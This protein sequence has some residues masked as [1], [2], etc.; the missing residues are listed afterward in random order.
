MW[1]PCRSSRFPSEAR[2]SGPPVRPPMARSMARAV[3]GASGTVTTLP[4]FRVAGGPFLSLCC[5]ACPLVQRAG[6]PGCSGS[7]GGGTWIQRLAD[8]SARLQAPVSVAGVVVGDPGRLQLGHAPGGV[9]HLRYRQAEPVPQAPEPFAA[10]PGDRLLQLPPVGEIRRAGGGA[11][12]GWH[13]RCGQAAWALLIWCG[14]VPVHCG[15]LSGFARLPAC[16]RKLMSSAMLGSRLAS[17]SRAA[18]VL[19]T[20]NRP[21][22]G[23]QESARP[24][25]R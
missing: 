8:P 6:R 13:S 16:C 20:H 12:D 4:P 25:L 3:R 14:R 15:L 10:G 5:V 22:E 9:V 2:K 7:A 21:Q 19:T 18:E 17:L 23:P 1:G 24:A 11:R